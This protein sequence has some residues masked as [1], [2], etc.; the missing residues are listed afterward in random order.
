MIPIKVGSEMSGFSN[1]VAWRGSLQQKLALALIAAAFLVFPPILLAADWTAR[2]AVLNQLMGHQVL[3]LNVHAAA[4][5]K[6]LF[7]F[8]NIALQRMATVIRTSADIDA[9][10]IRDADN[11]VVARSGVLNADTPGVLRTATIEYDN[12]VRAFDIGEIEIRFNFA[13]A[14]ETRR[15]LYWQISTVVAASLAFVVLVA[16]WVSQR[17]ILK[18][19][20]RMMSAVERSTAERDFFQADWTSG[21]EFGRM[22]SHFNEMQSTLMQ[23]RAEID[24][25]KQRI[26][27]TYNQTPAMLFSID[28]SGVVVDVS[29]FWL[30]YTGY[31][32]DQVVGTPMDALFQ[33]EAGVSVSQR[34]LEAV[35]GE[36]VSEIWD[37]RFVKADGA[38]ID[39]CLTRNVDRPGQ[40]GAEPT[41]CVMFDISELKAA[42]AALRRLARRDSLTGLP[43]RRCFKETLET[44]LSDANQSNGRVEVGFIDLDRFKWVNDH[45]GHHAGDEL[46]RHT[47]DRI[48]AAL[49]PTTFFARLGGDEFAVMTT[50]PAGSTAAFVADCIDASLAKPFQINGSEVRIGASVGFAAYPCNAE[51][52]G[53][54]LRAADLAMYSCKRA[55]KRSY[56]QYDD[57]IGREAERVF[58]VEKLLKSGEQEDRFFLQY[59][60]IVALPSDRVVAAEALIR[61]RDRQGDV[62][63]PGDFISVAEECGFMP[64]LGSYALRAGLREYANMNARLVAAAPDRPPLRLSVNLS[65]AQIAPSLPD[66]IGMLLDE[67]GVAGEHLMLEITES[68]LLKDSGELR[69]VFRGLRKLGCSIALD[70]FGTGYSSLCYLNDFPVDCLK[71][72]RSFV[73]RLD[74]DGG[75]SQDL[76][77]RRRARAVLNGVAQTGR[78]LGIKTVAEGVETLE[79]RRIVLEMGLNCGQGFLWSRPVNAEKFCDVGAPAQAVVNA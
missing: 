22:V 52:A 69:S 54:L 20:F 71:I 36:A 74:G 45:L 79:Q 6:P 49:P 44:A 24:T 64:Q 37:C 21:D 50:S 66:T 75:K 26:S 73:R 35:E 32:R 57:S 60:P 10:E 65:P 4:V 59:Q 72:D 42:E 13:L 43:N 7:D 12:G 58:E 46:L 11:R 3:D 76:D 1:M 63:P 68:V 48:A 31:R 61:M 77:A 53:D 28:G 30:Q 41:L 62:I 38:A 78:D 39:V 9:V 17:I 34:L 14:T 18:P 40:T 27:R 51:S 23:S 70:D 56:G 19:L 8:D 29:E 33:L 55:G 25:A 15:L 5:S 47:A 2:R 16:L 67:A